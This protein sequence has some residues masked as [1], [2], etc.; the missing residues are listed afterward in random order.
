MLSSENLLYSIKIFISAHFAVC[1]YGKVSENHL[2]LQV[3][4]MRTFAQ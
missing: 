2:V 1:S 4:D 3:T